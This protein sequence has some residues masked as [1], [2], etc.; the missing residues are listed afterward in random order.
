[1]FKETMYHSTNSDNILLFYYYY[2]HNCL[3]FTSPVCN[4]TATFRISKFLRNI[5]S[6]FKPFVPYVVNIITDD[7]NWLVNYTA[8]F[9]WSVKFE[10][11]KQST[12]SSSELLWVP[13][14]FRKN[15][16]FQY[17]L[18]H[19]KYQL[20][21]WWMHLQNWRTL[22]AVNKLQLS[23]YL[24]SFSISVGKLYHYSVRFKTS[25][26]EIVQCLAVMWYLLV[27]K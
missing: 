14:Y 17:V 13:A 26:N 4:H 10:A 15:A 8:T 16:R 23:C 25:P 3:F 9:Y 21:S 27:H 7:D 11:N 2:W 20:I 1:M 18:N 19:K 22:L 6:Y 12:L 5:S 24:F